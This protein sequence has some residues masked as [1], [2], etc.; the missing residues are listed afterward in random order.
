MTMKLILI[1]MM[2]IVTTMIRGDYDIDDLNDDDVDVQ[3][4]QMLIICLSNNNK[5]QNR[6]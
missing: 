1:L 2:M 5:R 6:L 4:P 3:W